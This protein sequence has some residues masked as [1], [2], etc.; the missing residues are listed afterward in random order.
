MCKKACAIID[1]YNTLDERIVEMGKFK[2]A[3]S[4]KSKLEKCAFV[5]GMISAIA[6]IVLGIL[7]LVDVWDGAIVVCELSMAICMI[8]QAILQW[9]T[10]KILALFSLGVAIFILAVACF[11]LFIK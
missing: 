2:E 7:Q 8:S 1:R 5:I 11:I 3:F 4:N 6:T 10:S 9:K